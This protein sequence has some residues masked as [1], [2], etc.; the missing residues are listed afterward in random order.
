MYKKDLNAISRLSSEQYRV[1]QQGAT[2]YPGSGEH[3]YNNEPG[4]YVDVV[5]G[6]P[7]F[8]SFDPGTGWPSF[9]RPIV[10]RPDAGLGLRLALH[11]M[12]NTAVTGATFDIDGGQ[13][14]VEG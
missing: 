13:Q 5:S 3:L 1:T 8:A 11:L 7:P 14:L 4:I 9:T 10:N 6:E 12:T 2:E